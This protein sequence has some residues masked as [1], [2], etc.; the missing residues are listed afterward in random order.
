MTRTS[1]SFARLD[2]DHTLNIQQWTG[3]ACYGHSS[4]L[5][6]YSVRGSV[7]GCQLPLHSLAGRLYF[8]PL[9]AVADRTDGL[10][11]TGAG[12]TMLNFA[13]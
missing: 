7:S 2:L 9:S 11:I 10:A 6:I 3:E 5:E 13:A 12:A 8:A 4:D 1:E